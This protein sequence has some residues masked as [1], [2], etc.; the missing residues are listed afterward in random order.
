MSKKDDTM[1]SIKIYTLAPLDQNEKEDL[2]F[3][4]Q[5][6]YILKKLTEDIDFLKKENQKLK[7][8]LDKLEKGMTSAS[9]A[10]KTGAGG[11]FKFE[12]GKLTIYSEKYFETNDNGYK[13]I[14]DV[15]S[16]VLERNIQR[17]ANKA[18]NNYKNLESIYIPDSV[19]TIGDQAFCDCISLK[20]IT[21]PESVKNIGEWAFYKCDRLEEVTIRS[22]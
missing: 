17:I 3:R 6:K 1:P 11:C 4:Y 7:E 12:N 10:V 14:Q 18:F 8:R 16:I 20:S 2:I 21:I 9:A 19:E 15:E 5:S 22:R 13:N